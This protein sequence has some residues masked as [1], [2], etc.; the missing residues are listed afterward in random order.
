MAE[1]PEINGL[2][3]CVL[4]KEYC[5]QMEEFLVRNTSVLFD[6]KRNA[7]NLFIIDS[8]PD[9]CDPSCL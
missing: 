9:T 4:G 3:D 8:E 7:K 2:F 5:L 6:N 1:V